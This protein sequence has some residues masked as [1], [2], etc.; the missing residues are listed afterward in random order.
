MWVVICAQPDRGV[1]VLVPSP[2]CIEVVQHGG[3]SLA[4]VGRIGLLLWM[5][6]ELPADV[7]LGI[8]RCNLLPGKLTR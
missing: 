8:L 6:K 5:P 7:V 4:A 3:L 2:R 1:T